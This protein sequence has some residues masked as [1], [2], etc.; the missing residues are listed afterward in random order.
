[1][2]YCYQIIPAIYFLLTTG[3]SAF[4]FHGRITT[5]KAT[6]VAS[7]VDDNVDNTT[8]I[9]SRPSFN[10]NLMSQALPFLKCPPILAENIDVPG[11]VG[12]DPLG[13]VQDTDDLMVYQEAEI[14]HA[15]LA[16]LVCSLSSTFIA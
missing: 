12:F 4:V 6:S 3:T 10:K 7:S 13:F 2:M 9:V 11:N 16:M 15:R 5:I 1:M 14:K 8:P